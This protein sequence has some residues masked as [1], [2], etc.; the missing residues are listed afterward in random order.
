MKK[1]T[2]FI[3]ITTMVLSLTGCVNITINQPEPTAETQQ[4]VQP[5]QE[6]G[7]TTQPEED[8][9]PLTGDE[10][11]AVYE[12]WASLVGYWNTTEKGFVILD[13]EDS[14]T[15]AFS[16]GIW[17]AGGGRGWGRV[18]GI[19]KSDDMEFTLKVE[20]PHKEATDL[21]PEYPQL[22][23]IVVIDYSGK[24]RDGKIQIKI[25]DEDFKQYRFAGWLGEAAYKEFMQ[26]YY[27]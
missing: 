14:H 24:D 5:T 15:A 16:R 4:T 3:L 2:L 21:D 6:A 11:T 1:L 17:E 20:Y 27:G 18:T 23:Q 19:K 13:M 10:M 9:P 25:G 22:E 12:Q 26:D 7:P 8:F